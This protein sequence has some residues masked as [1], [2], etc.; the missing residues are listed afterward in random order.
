[1]KCIRLSTS[2]K[3]FDT[4]INSMNFMDKKKSIICVGGTSRS[5][6]TL[7]GLVL[8]NDPN[9]MAL[10]EIQALFHPTRKHHFEKIAELQG[11][12]VWSI[13]L[14][15][16]KKRLYSNLS[17][18]FPDINV[19]VDTSKDPFWFQYHYHYNCKRYKI[20]NLLIY[21]TPE[22]LAH[23]FIKRNQG[24]NWARV[25][26]HYH[27]KYFG[28]INNFIAISYNELVSNDDALISLCDKLELRYFD[29]K[30]NYWEKEQVNFFGSNSVKSETGYRSDRQLDQFTRKEIAC[31]NIKDIVAS[32]QAGIMKNHDEAINLIM[33]ELENHSVMKNEVSRGA[34][35]KYGYWAIKYVYLKQIIKQYL[36]YFSPQDYFKAND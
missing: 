12:K 29:T 30:K 20:F 34:D 10:G 13:I 9:A 7:V 36:R 4:R 1:M 22:E 31:E 11:D 18:Y 19:F 28:L 24:A 6:S 14:K 23:S 26:K 32:E 8:A 5:G 15:E 3:S 16:G 27:K 25:Y 21:K 17:K 2:N 35:I 33:R